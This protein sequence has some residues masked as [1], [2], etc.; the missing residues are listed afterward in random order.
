M[1]TIGFLNWK[2]GVGK[3]TLAL[4]TAVGLSRMLAGSEH[5]ILFLD[6]DKQGNASS[7][8]ETESDATH[9]SLT[10]V[11][12]DGVPVREVIQ[13]TRYEGIDIIPADPSLVA[14]N[15]AV[16]RDTGRRQ[17][18]ILKLALQDIEDR[19]MFCIIDNPPD[20][21]ATVFNTLAVIDDLIAVTL[22]NRFSVDGIEELQ[23]E[24]DKLQMGQEIRG[25]VVNQYTSFC[26][27]IYQELAKR[28]YMFPHIR[29]GANTQRWLDTVVNTHQS[30]FELSPHSGYARDVRHFLDKLIEVIDAQYTG[31]KVL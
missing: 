14:A 12:L 1:R 16:L 17:D 10:H 4:H 25:V 22:P 13:K 3:T 15:L 9:P 31:K 26:S 18:T 28:Y 6:S 19:Y 21:N 20:I 8:F 11:L 30:I 5:R 23:K 24:L 27:D 7:W 29:G 2:G